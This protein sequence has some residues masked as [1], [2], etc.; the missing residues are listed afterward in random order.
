M[1]SALT[2][3][4]KG[5]LYI[6]IAAGLLSLSPALSAQRGGRGGG[7]PA[8]PAGPA[9]RMPN[10]KP[11]LAGHWNNPYTPN[12]AARVVDPMT[13]Q[14]L[15]FARQGEVLKDAVDPK[16]TFDLPYTDWGLKKWKQY[17]P[18]G[19]GDYTGNC[20]PFGMSRNINSP[21]GTQILQSPD[22]VALLFEQNTWFHWIP[23][24][25]KFKW[26]EDLPESW[27][28]VS[29]GHWE[30]DTLVVVTKDFNGYTKL[31]TNGHP[32][33]KEMVLTNTFTRTDSNTIAHTVTVHDPKTYTRDWMNVRTW[34]LKPAGDV[35]MEYSCEENN[36]PN[37]LNG[38]IK[39]WHAPEDDE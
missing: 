4:L 1:K 35:I 8:A 26:P 6:V 5:S 31:D 18:V 23:T 36:L 39:V 11:D 25:D 33:S 24:T 34:R 21:H 9:P 10:G 15:T 27:N 2:A 29:V 22:A 17:D 30:G 32:H 38:A 37:I 3:T 16:R 12:M 19:K 20:L 28:G 13:R 14:P 7:A